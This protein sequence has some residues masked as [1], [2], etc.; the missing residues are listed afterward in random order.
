ML[1][2]V[3]LPGMDG[4]GSLFAPFIASM[5]TDF[6]FIIVRYPTAEGLSYQDLEQIA[7]QSLPS[8]RDFII[9]GESFSGPIAVALAAH[10]PKGLIGLVLCCTFIKCPRPSYKH[11]RSLLN[12]LPLKLTPSF[13]YNY[14]LLDSTSTPSLESA[15]NEAVRQVSGTAFRARFRAVLNVDVSVQMRSIQVPILYLR[16]EHDRLVPQ[17]ASYDIAKVH[18]HVQV[19]SI[20]APHFVLQVASNQAADVIRNFAHEICAQVPG[21]DLALSNHQYIKLDRR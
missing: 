15:I 17:A 18:P 16:A 21:Q 2:I 9:L 1:T 8:D 13:I 3:L 12:F 20:K 10:K 11:L 5:G 14:F 19:I 6:N 7:R 4:T